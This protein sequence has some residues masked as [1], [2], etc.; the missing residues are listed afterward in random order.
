MSK[1]LRLSLVLFISDL[2]LLYLLHWL[3]HMGVNIHFVRYSF[4]YFMLMFIFGI[5]NCT[6][7]LI[8]DEFQ[9]VVTAHSCFFL[10]TQAMNALKVWTFAFGL[11]N[12][13]I[14]VLMMIASISF[15]RM[16]RLWFRDEIAQ[17]LLIFGTG[18][19]AAK[20]VYLYQTNRFAMSKVLGVVNVNHAKDFSGF[21]QKV[22][23]FDCPMIPYDELQEYLNN[24]Q[25]DEVI[26]ALPDANK[27]MNKEIYNAIRDKVEVIK[28]IPKINGIIS[29]QADIQDFDGTVLISSAQGRIKND[30][31]G[32]FMKRI[33]DICAGLVGLLLLIPL[34]IYVKIGNLKCG[35]HGPLFYLQDRVGKNGKHFKIIKFRSM[36][37]G[38]E[39]KLRQLMEENPEIRKEYETTKKLKDD[40]RITKF[41]E[42]LR[43]SSIDEM[44]QLLNVLFGQMSVVGPRPY[45]ITEIPDMGNTYTSVI[46]CKPGITGMWQTHG[47]SQASWEDRLF[48]DEYYYRNWTI[49]LDMTILF[50]TAGVV[51][52]HDGAY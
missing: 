37:I 3:F 46:G 30:F 2:L 13:L 9:K 4:M 40:P 23:H 50:K 5:Y 39:E 29:Y 21:K 38:A 19:H 49:W 25:V 24:H 52:Q 44:P 22:C 36:V 20:L 1:K 26:I 51:L 27:R 35:D 47:R 11:Y 34:C 41:G 28:T 16:Y 45:L 33:V 42:K 15:N 14:S 12:L 18:D 31:A 48:F 6:T 8:W 10:A 43:S 17:N 7:N 32:L